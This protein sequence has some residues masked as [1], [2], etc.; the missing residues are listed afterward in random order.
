MDKKVLHDQTDMEIM[1]KDP[2]MVL[3]QDEVATEHILQKQCSVISE[4]IIFALY[5]TYLMITGKY[6]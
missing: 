4:H 6:I 1:K 3:L 2:D 5:N